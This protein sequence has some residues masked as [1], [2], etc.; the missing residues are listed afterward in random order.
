MY[1][2]AQ[3]A[4]IANNTVYNTFEGAG[5][6]IRS[7]AVVKNNKIWDTTG[8][9]LA[10]YQMK[11]AGPS[12]KTVIENNELFFTKNKPKGRHSPLLRIQSDN[13]FPLFYDTF[14]VRNNKLSI[15]EDTSDEKQPPLIYADNVFD[16]LTFSGNHLVDRRSRRRFFSSN[17]TIRAEDKNLNF[18]NEIK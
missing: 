9:A 8:S 13:R 6:S 11:P 5:I 14:E 17:Y 18:F 2:K 3:D 7:T 15:F 12:G 10:V 16:N 4:Y 1:I